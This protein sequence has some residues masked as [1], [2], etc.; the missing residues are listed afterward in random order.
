MEPHTARTE[1]VGDDLRWELGLSRRVL[2]HSDARR[3]DADAAR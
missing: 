3:L 2:D 1:E